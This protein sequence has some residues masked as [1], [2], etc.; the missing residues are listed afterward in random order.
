MT[1]SIDS[2]RRLLRAVA[3][4]GLLAIVSNCLVASDGQDAPPGLGTT[5]GMGGRTGATAT[6]TTVTSSSTTVGSAGGPATGGSAGGPR[7]SGP[8][9]NGARECGPGRNCYFDCAS[10]SSSCVTA[11][12]G[13]DGSR[14]TKI[15]DCGSGM[16]C[17][18]YSATQSFCKVLCVGDADCPTGEVCSGALGCAAGGPRTATVCDQPCHDLVTAGAS[19]CGSGFKCG[20]GCDG[21]RAKLRCAPAGVFRSG[22]C[23]SDLECAAGFTCVG[24]ACAQACVTNADCTAGGACVKEMFCG[25]TPSGNH[26][27]G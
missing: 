22:P 4:L 6:G 23:S 16:D 24:G 8:T 11:G 10:F 26:Y 20:V 1:M 15:E 7:C 12:P 25:S 27:C 17:V 9:P 18:A 5:G 19:T 13:T 3:S 2:I 21:G 14:C